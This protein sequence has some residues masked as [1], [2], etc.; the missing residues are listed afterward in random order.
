MLPIWTFSETCVQCQNL[1]LF[2]IDEFL[3]I[4]KTQTDLGMGSSNYIR[5]VMTKALGENKAQSV[6]GRITPSSS[7]RPI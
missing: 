4:I 5:N 3:S 7:D 2:P 6:L 1:L